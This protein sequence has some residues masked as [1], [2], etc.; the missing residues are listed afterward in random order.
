MQIQFHRLALSI[1]GWENAGSLHR[2]SANAICV[3]CQSEA[4]QHVASAVLAACRTVEGSNRP[5]RLEQQR[6]TLGKYCWGGFSPLF[7]G[8]CPG[9][10]L[11][12]FFG[13]RH[14][15]VLCSGGEG[16]EGGREC[17]AGVEMMLHSWGVKE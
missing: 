15:A 4:L 6:P 12:H 3:F 9:A 17:G 2:G 1:R 11:C 5:G 7:Q 10:Y 13:H 16:L 14:G 8:R